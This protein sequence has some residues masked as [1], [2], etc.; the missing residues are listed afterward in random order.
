MKA[1]AWDGD[2]PISAGEYY[3][4]GTYHGSW[5][6]AMP[7]YTTVRSPVDG[8]VLDYVTGVPNVPGGSGSPSNWVLIGFQRNG[9]KECYYF[10]HLS[11]ATVKKGQKVKAGDKIGESGNSG[12]SSGPHLHLTLQPGWKNAYTRYDYLNTKSAVYAPDKGWEDM[13]LSADDKD[14]IKGQID[15]AIEQGSNQSAKKVWDE[16][17]ENTT[18][19]PPQKYKAQWFLNSILDKVKSK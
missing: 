4:S 17:L 13:G 7:N 5:D 15:R 11:K 18:V 3:S 16:K 6:V 8:E 12:N 14:W 1:P 9:N 2:W 10:Q 19:E